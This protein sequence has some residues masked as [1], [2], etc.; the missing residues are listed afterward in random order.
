MRL[1]QASLSHTGEKLDV[2]YSVVGRNVL[3]RREE[4][5]PARG[6]AFYPVEPRPLSVSP[7]GHPGSYDW[8][9]RGISD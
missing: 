8:S 9:C 2:A 5:A 3:H 6:D 1:K 4:R 7:P